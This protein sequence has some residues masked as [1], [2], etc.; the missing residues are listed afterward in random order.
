MRE[1]KPR[2]C[3]KAREEK[4]PS[5]TSTCCSA[6][7]SSPRPKTRGLGSLMETTT[8]ATPARTM[9]S[10]QGGGP[11]FHVAAGLEIHI[12]RRSPGPIAGD[13]QGQNLRVGLPRLPVV[14]FAHDLAVPHHHR[15]H[16]GVGGHGIP[17]LLRQSQGPLHPPS[18]GRDTRGSAHPLTRSFRES[19][20]NRSSLPRTEKRRAR[21]AKSA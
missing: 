14:P 4:R 11:L 16:H 9:A 5:E 2:F 20:T 15:T 12:E 18:I 19:A 13:P 21:R 6:S 1:E 10:V 7:R 3:S 17:P 8:R